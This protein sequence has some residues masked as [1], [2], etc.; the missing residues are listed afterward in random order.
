MPEERYPDA[1]AMAED[2]E[3]LADGA[4]TLAANAGTGW[5]STVFKLGVLVMM[6]IV[7]LAIYN[8]PKNSMATKNS[9]DASPAK[10]LPATQLSITNGLV[11]H[12]SFD[13]N[14]NDT[15][16][17]DL[18]GQ[19]NGVELT[20]DRTGKPKSAYLF[21]GRDSYVVVPHSPKLNLSNSFTLSLWFTV[22][23]G[24]P[25]GWMHLISKH[26]ANPGA[27]GDGFGISIPNARAP[28]GGLSFAFGQA[29]LAAT[30]SF[31]PFNPDTWHHVL[32]ISNG[33][34]IT[35]YLNNKAVASAKFN[36]KLTANS[37]PLTIG[38]QNRGFGQRNHVGK[39]D[40]VRIYNRALSTEEIQ[41][42]QQF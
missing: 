23:G 27:A 14:A 33:E 18:H 36:G 13:G 12:Y 42:L 11:A 40:D 7:G 16:G 38:G 22:Q 41:L 1:K 8:W 9:Q 34:K 26:R 20:N 39:I 24:N 17:H 28:E 10:S 25:R 29:K 32:V 35:A 31:F 30:T 6:L 5:R 2:L 37:E 3:R 15:S 19:P 21:K 4:P